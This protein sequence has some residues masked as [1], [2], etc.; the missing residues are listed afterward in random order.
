MRWSQ[1]HIVRIERTNV[2][3]APKKAVSSGSR[4]PRRRLHPLAERGLAQNSSDSGTTLPVHPGVLP[5]DRQRPSYPISLR[6]RM[7]PSHGT[8]RARSTRNPSRGGIRPRQVRAQSAVAPVEL[9]LGFLAVHVVDAIR[10]SEMKPTGSRSCHMKWLGSKFSPNPGGC[11]PRRGR[12]SRSSSRTRFPTGAPRAQTAPDLVEHV[13]N[14]I[15][16]LGKIVESA[17]HHLIRRG[18]EHCHRVPDRGSGK[19]GHRLHPNFA[20]ARRCP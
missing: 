2:T 5:F 11:P 9:P 3:L 4:T 8:S 6:I 7:I 19:S 13:N 20:A 16:P 17:L 1:C 18:R 12:A 15:P 14:R 10:N